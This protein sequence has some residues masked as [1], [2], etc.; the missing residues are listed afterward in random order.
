M[1][2]PRTSPDSRLEPAPAPE[3]ASEP[4][5]YGLTVDA[6]T[7]QGCVRSRNEDAVTVGGWRPHLG[8]SVAQVR[9]G[10]GSAQFVAVADGMGGHPAGDE[11]SRLVLDVLEAN[12]HRTSGQELVQ[13][14]EEMNLALHTYA[15]GHP[16]A[17]G[18]GTT[19][20]GLALHARTAWVFNVGDSPVYRLT[21]SFLGLLSV[22]DRAPRMPGQPADSPTRALS[23]CLGGTSTPARIRPHVHP[24][25]VHPGDRFLVCSDGLTDVL[26]TARI[27]QLA[28]PGGPEAVTGLLEAALAAGAPD[29]V[30][31][32]LV[33]VDG[34]LTDP[35]RRAW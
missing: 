8:G 24:E 15:A 28:A 11:A 2:E 18:A 35:G 29:N 31:I 32:A 17:A 21:E 6:V 3:P 19:L 1:T 10:P 23:Q 25:P 27:G 33:E 5:L 12:G 13:L 16:Y 20:A 9:L 14:I 34:V 26:D 30:S 7:H 22:D 4:P